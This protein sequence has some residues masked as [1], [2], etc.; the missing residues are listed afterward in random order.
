MIKEAYIAGM[1]AALEK[2]GKFDPRKTLMHTGAGLGIGGIG[3][4][5]YGYFSMPSKEEFSKNKKRF[6]P[7]VRNDPDL[8]NRMRRNRAAQ[9]GVIGGTLGG[10][11]GAIP[12]VLKNPG[13]ILIY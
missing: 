12:H 2:V 8:Y 5:A 7:S 4:T 13:E 1:K 9:F 10:L 3:G 6:H 11:G